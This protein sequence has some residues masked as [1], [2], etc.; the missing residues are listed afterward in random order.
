MLNSP[1]AP[2]PCFSQEEADR[3]REVPLSNRVNYWTGQETRS[4]ETEFAR[5]TQSRHAIALTNGTV[6]LRQR[7]LELSGETQWIENGNAASLSR[8]T[9]IAG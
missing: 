7:S 2:W 6:A 8:C 9:P 1:V 5:W 4:F 3:V